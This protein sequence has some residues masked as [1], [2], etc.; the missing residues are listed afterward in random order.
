M[1]TVV[2]LRH[3]RTRAN[4]TGVLAGRS[5]GVGLDDRGLEQAATAAQR[6]AGSPLAAVV[7]SPLQRCRQTAAA[8][9]AEHPRLD[10]D[11]D[12][13]LVECGYGEWTGRPLKELAKD[14]LWTTVQDQPS[15]ARFPGGESLLEM[16]ARAQQTIHDL[17]RTIGA[18]H[19]P[20][21]VWVAV[22]HGDVIKAIL[23]GAL[24][25]HLDS[26]QRILVDPASISVIRLGQHR[27]HVACMNT[28]AG[29]LTA[30]LTPTKRGRRR[31][32][33]GPQVGGGLGSAD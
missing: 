29:D 10:L 32:P 20:D 22:S 27:P 26:F 6:L 16:A 5:A 4:A 23:A 1:T 19:G 24:G 30:M 15:A 8:V 31:R 3:G 12:R 13:G 33:R 9:L 17:D 14:P 7:S 2:L 11:T 25:M 18:E 28:T 21:A